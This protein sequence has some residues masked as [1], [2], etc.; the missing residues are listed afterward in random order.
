M[1]T[2][3]RALDRKE[4]RILYQPIV[5]LQTG[6]FAALEALIRWMHPG[7][8]LVSPDSFIPV[9]EENGFI[10][11]LGEWILREVCWQIK[12]WKGIYSEVR[13]AVNLSARQL[14]DKNFPTV[15][16]RIIKETDISPA[17][18]DLEITESAVI[19]NWDLVGET[20]SDLLS[21]GVRLCLDDFGTG[22][23][24]LSYLHR[25]PVTQLKIDRSFIEKMVLSAEHAGIV[26]TILDLAGHLNME[27]VAEG[28]ET[29]EQLA[30][31]KRMKCK[32]GQGYFFAKPLDAESATALVSDRTPFALFSH[33]PRRPAV[34]F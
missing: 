16:S 15:L 24:S 20:L 2:S 12:A 28:I 22:Y 6:Q 30:Q 8:G 4:F 9:A 17:N 23:S 31:L 18:I 32:F 27:V 19:N 26:Q 33:D 25:L 14:R 11:P 10:V 13:V 21:L 29:E 1:K 34:S 7:R 3:G 5:D